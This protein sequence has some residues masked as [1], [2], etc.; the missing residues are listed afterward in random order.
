[1]AAWKYVVPSDDNVA[2]NVNGVDWW[3]CT[4][5]KCRATGTKGFYTKHSSSDHVF[6]TTGPDSRSDVEEENE[7]PSASL[8][9]VE[10]VE[11]ENEDDENDHI[12]D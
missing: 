1:M 3:F 10:D 7:T 5:C 12:Y 4:H 2:K 9:A 6:R 11:D 8:A